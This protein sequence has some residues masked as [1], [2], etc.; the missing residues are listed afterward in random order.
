MIQLWRLQPGGNLSSFHPY[1]TFP[2]PVRR[3]SSFSNVS[4]S[5]DN[6]TL[7]LDRHDESIALW[8]IQTGHLEQWSAHNASVWTCSSFAQTEKFW[9]AVVTIARC[10]C[11]MYKRITVCTC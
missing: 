5:P 10:G 6:R 2:S 1:K 7:A 11:G 4:F 8:N 3:I 9:Q